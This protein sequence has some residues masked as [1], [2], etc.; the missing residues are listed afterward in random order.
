M[1]PKKTFE[2]NLKDLEK[3]VEKLENGSTSL[4]EAITLFQ[5]GRALS[6]ACENRLQ[7]V[8]LKIRE[9]VEDQDG[10]LAARDLDESRDESEES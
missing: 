10:A 5:K 1:T 3:I 4:D 8:E 9:L 6:K 7:E 2:Q